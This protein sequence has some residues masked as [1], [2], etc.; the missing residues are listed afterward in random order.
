MGVIGAVVNEEVVDQTASEAV[1]GKHALHYMEEEGIFA[2]FEVLVLSF[3]HEDLGSEF[4]LTAGEAGVAEHNVV[5]PFF[6]GEHHFVGIYNNN[7]VATLGVGSVA[8]FVFPAKDFCHFRAKAS[9]HLIGSVDDDPSALN[10]VGAGR[11]GFVT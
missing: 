8:G 9:E 6:A 2:G 11:K 10:V 5:G 4:A 7:T 3:L 1:F